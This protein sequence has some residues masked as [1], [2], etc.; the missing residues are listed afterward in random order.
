MK[1]LAIVVAALSV[2]AVFTA[3]GDDS[4]SSSGSGTLSC[5]VEIAGQKTCTEISFATA[6]QKSACTAQGGTIGSSCASGEDLK[7]EV[8]GGEVQTTMYYY[9]LGAAKDLINCDLFNGGNLGDDSSPSSPSSPSTPSTGSGK[10]SCTIVTVG[11]KTCTEVSFATAEQKS[12]CTAQGGTIGTGCA[13]GEDLKCDV[14]EGGV[15]TTMYMYNL[16][17]YKELFSCADFGA[18]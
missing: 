18:L 10:Y 17:A 6:E 14:N 11:Q 15:Q 4:S 8:N 9:D 3:C 13:S 5:T 2:A 1:K 12:A 16:G 7:C